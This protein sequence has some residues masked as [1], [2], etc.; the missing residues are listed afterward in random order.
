MF[1]YQ[2]GGY[3]YDSAAQKTEHGGSEEELNIPIYYKDAW[4]KPG[5]ITQYEM[6]NSTQKYPMKSYATTR[7][8]HSSDFIRLRNL[9]FGITLPNNW[10][11][12]A[13]L[14]N[15]RFYASGNN[16]W[17]WAK[18]DFYDPETAVAGSAAFNTP[19]LKT[20]T[21]GVNITL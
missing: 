11:K 6:P 17:T 15:V 8:L 13:G 21:F 10:T 14:Q 9:T 3:S 19:P 16:L 20:M 1:S 18:W 2:F 4:K 12:K 5:D 7:R